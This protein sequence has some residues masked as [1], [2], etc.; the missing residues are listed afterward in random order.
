MN[1][2]TALHFFVQNVFWHMPVRFSC[3][4]HSH[5]VFFL[6]AAL[7][8]GLILNSS[9]SLSS[10]SGL[11]KWQ[12]QLHH[13]YI[14]GVHS[15]CRFSAW[16]TLSYLPWHVRIYIKYV[17]MYVCMKVYAMLACS[18]C[19]FFYSPRLPLYTIL[20]AVNISNCYSCAGS[21]RC[22]CYSA[23]LVHFLSRFMCYSCSFFSVQVPYLLFG[24][25]WVF[26]LFFLRSCFCWCW[27]FFI[28]MTTTATMVMAMTML[29][30][31]M[32]KERFLWCHLRKILSFLQDCS[33]NRTNNSTNNNSISW[34]CHFIL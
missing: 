3:R 30:L 4:F 9:S 32:E 13:A 20:C 11:V 34:C 25:Y 14:D 2:S 18:S 10:L 26:L 24:I 31:L 28:L 12:N 29:M 16:S 22:R 8:R 27:F 1:S 33:T 7:L 5:H 19:K 17:Y 6:Y 15:S 23:I 21:N